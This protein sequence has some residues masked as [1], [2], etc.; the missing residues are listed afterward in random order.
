VSRFRHIVALFLATIIH[1][2]FGASPG[3]L[4]RGITRVSVVKLNHAMKLNHKNLIV[5][6]LEDCAVLFNGQRIAFTAGDYKEF[7]SSDNLTL[8]PVGS[9]SPRIALV[10]VVASSQALTITSKSLASHQEM[11][12]ASDRNQTLVV[13]LDS[14]E[15]RDKQDL[16]AEGQPWRASETRLIRLQRGETAW[17]NQGMHRVKN[18]GSTVAKFITIEW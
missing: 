4:Q 9:A 1:P 17:L 16:A 18:A 12:D 14:L 2:A 15:I 11:E 10:E 13:A 6:P 5:V 3:A 7:S 8:R